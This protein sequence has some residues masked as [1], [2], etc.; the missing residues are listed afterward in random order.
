MWDNVPYET[1]AWCTGTAG[2]LHKAKPAGREW[3][4]KHNSMALSAGLTWYAFNSESMTREDVRRIIAKLVK[5]RL[6]MVVWDE[7]T[8]FRTPGSKRTLMARALARRVPYRRILEGTVVTNNLL[9]AYSQYELLQHGALGFTR[10]DEFKERYGRWKSKGFNRQPLL[11]GYQNESELRNKMAQYSSVVLRSDCEDLPE[12]IRSI[13]EIN[14]S[15]EQKR[16]YTE[17]QENFCAE[18]GGEPV[19]L[20]QQIAKLLKLQQ[21]VSGFLIDSNRKIHDISGGN[22]R[23]EALL[24]ELRLTSGKTIIWCQFQE[25]IARVTRRLR[26]EGRRFV[27]YHGKCNA[28]EKARALD[29]FQNDST[30]TD[31]VGQP[32]AGGRGLELSAADMVIWYSHIFNAIIHQQATERATKMGGSNINVTYIMAP[33]I[34]W[35]IR[36]KVNKRINVANDVAGRGLQQVLREISL[37]LL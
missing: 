19:P 9:H 15:D 20:K 10:F 6:C 32:Q 36:D 2:A 12:T 5:K 21:V 14:L 13:V 26:L 35:Y 29:L 25:D 4:H 18:I 17:L 1:Q 34:D 28:T 37:S 24:E 30:Y 8:D 27:E 3:W 23:L 22:P 11:I 16:I 31:F 33:G 7:A